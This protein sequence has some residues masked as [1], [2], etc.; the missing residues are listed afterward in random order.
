MLDSG[1]Q[2][3]VA[4]LNGTCRNI[5]GYIGCHH[6]MYPPDML[7]NAGSECFNPFAKKRKLS[8]LPFRTKR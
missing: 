2:R 5:N 6:S 4:K 7:C 1:G 3:N 8:S